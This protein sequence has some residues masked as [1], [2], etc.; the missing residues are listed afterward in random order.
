MEMLMCATKLALFI[1]TSTTVGSNC[2]VKPQILVSV[3][4]E[5]SGLLDMAEERIKMSSVTTVSKTNGSKSEDKVSEL[6]LIR[7]AILGVLTPHIIS[8]T[9]MVKIGRDNQVELTT[10]VSVLTELFGQLVPT[11]LVVAL[12]STER[13]QVHTLL[14]GL[15]CLNKVL[16]GSKT[17]NMNW[18]KMKTGLP[19]KVTAKKF[20]QLEHSDALTD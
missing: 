15:P 12:A 9:T 2:L 10:L 3:L 18:F 1:T 4:T 16:T 14:S 13:A 8:T 11:K 7:M 17:S 6:M 20:G 19:L 5:L